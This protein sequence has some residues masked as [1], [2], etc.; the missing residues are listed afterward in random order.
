MKVTKRGLQ[1][2]GDLTGAGR[3]TP[4]LTHMD[5]GRRPQFLAEVWSEDSVPHCMDLPTVLILF[6]CL[7][8]FLRDFY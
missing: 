4:K 7:D 2:F 1:S 6:P 3:P 5:V 8:F